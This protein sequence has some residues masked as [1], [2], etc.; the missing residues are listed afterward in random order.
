PQVP[1]PEIP[2]A[3]ILHG[4]LRPV[5]LRQDGPVDRGAER[6]PRGED[7]HRGLLGTGDPE[8][9]RHAP[10]VGLAEAS[11]DERLPDM[12]LGRRAA[13]RAPS[14]SP[15]ASAG[16]TAVT[17]NERSPRTRTAAA[18]TK[19][20]STPPEKATMALLVS[21]R[22]SSRSPSVGIEASSFETARGRECITPHLLDGSTGQGGNRRAIIMLRHRVDDSAVEHAELHPHAMSVDLDLTERTLQLIAPG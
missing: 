9:P 2:E 13:P 12:V 17:A 6:H 11:F 18:A 1:H 20:E 7:R 4:A 21:T 22:Q 10:D 16:E 5:D 3:E 8:L 14:S 19:D 15:V